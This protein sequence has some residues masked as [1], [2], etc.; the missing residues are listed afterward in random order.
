MSDNPEDAPGEPTPPVIE[1]APVPEPPPESSPKSSPRSPITPKPRRRGGTP[2]PLTL[3]L[4][5][6]LGGAIWWVWTN[7]LPQ[8]AGR[9]QT[10]EAPGDAASLARLTQQAQ[11]HDQQLQALAARLDALEKRPAPVPAP[12]PAPDTAPPMPDQT[13]ALSKRL[14]DIAAHVDALSA[15]QDAQAGDVQKALTT[16]EAASRT[17]AETPPAAPASPPPADTG[18]APSVLVAALGADLGHKLEDGLAQQKTAA[19]Q[20]AARQKAALDAQ[21]A[22]LDALDQRLARL[23]QGSQ[24]QAT[25]GQD[26]AA[27]AKTQIAALESRVGKL[28]QGQGAVQGAAQDA[29]RAIRLEAAQ[30][31]LAAGQ[32]LGPLP[33]AP[34]ALA[35]FA[36]TAPPTEAGLRAAFPAV[37]EAARAASQ[38]DLRDRSFLDRALAR[39]QQSVT[40]RRGDQVIVGDP[41]SGVLAHARQALD[42]GDLKGAADALAALNG[43]AAA[44]THDWVAQVRALLDA[45]AALAAMARG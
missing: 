1:H 21:K 39:M 7:P 15:K 33:G 40:V 13:A 19:D 20:A 4:T 14:D 32:K 5:A 6:A 3:L 23:E 29:G 37:A 28:E 27:Q 17:Q 22:T 11:A 41:A 36:D 9:T 24:A 10:T 25:A 12:A 34:P 16:A 35:R 43:P 30:T 26:D 44:A 38:P 31:A 2:L 8:A 18:P 42:D 45:R